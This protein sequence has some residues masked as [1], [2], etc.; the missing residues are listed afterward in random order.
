MFNPNPLFH[1]V[2]FRQIAPT[3]L[4]LDNSHNVLSKK[5]LKRFIH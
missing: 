4:F 2:Y 3:F 1:M 5:I